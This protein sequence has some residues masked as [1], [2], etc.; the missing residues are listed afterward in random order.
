MDLKILLSKSFQKELE[1][2]KGKYDISILLSHAGM[3]ED[4]EFSETMKGID[5]IVNG[6]SHILMESVE[7][8]NN[9]IIHQS[10]CYGY[11]R[12]FNLYMVATEFF[13]II[14]D[15]VSR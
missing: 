1:D 3:R 14:H 6:H 4:R 2:N 12:T 13:N 10:G 15:L 5:I 8:V 11:F 7:K 9:T